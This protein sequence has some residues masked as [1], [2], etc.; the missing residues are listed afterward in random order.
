MDERTTTNGESESSPIT[1]DGG[2]RSAPSGAQAFFEQ[3]SETGIPDVTRRDRMARSLDRYVLA[4]MRVAWSDWRAKVGL[5][6]IVF[7]V[8][9]GTVGVMIYPEAEA[10]MAEPYLSW[11]QTWKYPLGADNMGRPIDRM[12]VHATPSVLKMALAGVLFSVGLAVVIGVVSGYKGGTVDYV[13]MNLTD[14]VMTIP[15]LPLVIVLAA[16]FQPQGAFV[17]GVILA[18]DSWP[19]LARSLRS[20]VLTVRDESYVEA[21]RTMGVPT[22]HILLKDII[23]QLMPY[24]MINA[25][26]AARSVIFAAVGLYFLGLLPFT[27]ANWGV[28]M[29]QAYST[30]GALANFPRAGHWLVPPM[31][32]LTLLSFGLIL[33]SQGMDRVFNTKIR[34]RHAETVD[35]DDDKTTLD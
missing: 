5:A 6:I 25:A 15:G 12:L 1:T 31:F 19:G 21:A 4:P 14:I 18:I 16:I 22:R 35:D 20:Q 10:N 28:M 26:N 11:F 17:V 23:P 32:M 2:E 30:G 3:R 9:I 33:F 7:I 29:N 24:V 13:L 27:Q 8:L 34:A